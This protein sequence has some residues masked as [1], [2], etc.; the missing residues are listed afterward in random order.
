MKERVSP[1]SKIFSTLI[2]I[3]VHSACFAFTPMDSYVSRV[4]G[5]HGGFKDGD[6]NEA[7]SNLPADVVFDD[8]GKRLFVA[9]QGNNRVRVIHT[10]EDNWVETLAG[11][12][13]AGS[14]DGP[15]SIATFN[16]PSRVNYIKGGL[17]VYD[18]GDHLFRT[19]DLKSGSV[20]LL[21]SAGSADSPR[22]RRG[23][24]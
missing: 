7:Q 23:V 13:I 1:V 22:T 18:A 17:V 8:E 19:I 9:D 5:G 12:G 3:A 21:V 20:S 16:A 11:T 2:L 14:Q 4:V 6:F 24:R 10:D 15:L